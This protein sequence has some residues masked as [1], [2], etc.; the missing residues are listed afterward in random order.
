MWMRRGGGLLGLLGALHQAQG[1]LG[2]ADSG[3][4]HGG[5]EQELGILNRDFGRRYER[6]CQA[7]DESGDD[8]FHMPPC[9][10]I[11]TGERGNG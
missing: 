2:V 1:R 9:T 4:V 8:R 7:D 11:Q 5:G 6:E 10:F 3:F